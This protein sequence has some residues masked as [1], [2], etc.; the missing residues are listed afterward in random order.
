MDGRFDFIL[1]DEDIR[2]NLGVNYDIR[3]MTMDEEYDDMIVEGPT[4]DEDDVI[5]KYLNMNL[6]FDV[7]TNNKRRG[8]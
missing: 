3:V 7:G 6:I 5:D 8:M 2:K 4:N 1:L